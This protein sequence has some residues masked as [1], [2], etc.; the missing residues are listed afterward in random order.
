M[1]RVL[2]LMFGLLGVLLVGACAIQPGGTQGA[3][4]ARRNPFVPGGAQLAATVRPGDSLSVQL[5]S[6]PD[7]A[8]FSV[9]V[10]DA[11]FIN[12]RYIGQI[13]AAGVAPSELARRIQQTYIERD[14]YKYIDVSVAVAERFVYV[15]GEVERPGRV[16]WT[17]DL[18]LTRAIT[19]AGGFSP[20][21]RETGVILSRDK[22]SWT[23]DARLAA[24]N[25]AEDASLAPGDR[26]T[27]PKSTF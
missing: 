8:E 13:R 23:L 1:S 16:M 27:V 6:I 12:L 2:R 4:H 20:Y 14:F 3:A 24:R 9:Q 22:D 26:V 17:P 19:A 21:A 7:A 5:Q 25:P 15:G 11:G 18:T 10:D